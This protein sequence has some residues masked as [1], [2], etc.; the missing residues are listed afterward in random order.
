M[1]NPSAPPSPSLSGT[2]G[3]P[4]KLIVFEGVDGSGK[5]TQIRHLA[6]VL[7]RAGIPFCTTREPGGT[8]LGLHLRSILMDRE[9]P[10]C[11]EAELFLFLADRVQHARD[12]LRPALEAGQV[13][14]SDRLSDATMAYQGFGAGLPRD[15]LATLNRLALGAIV[16]DLTFLLD[17]PVS[18]I[19]GRIRA[20]A[21]GQTRFEVLGRDYF[22]R[23]RQGYLEMARVHSD[24]TVVLDATRPPDELKD[25]VTRA[26][27]GR[28]P[29]ECPL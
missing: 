4:G 26:L 3:R 19:E 16:P 23:V 11:T 18:E 12:L 9:V 24:R 27:S 15:L 13:V 21:D 22:E 6:G 29:E 8:P 14:L 28:F 2:P 20:R 5:S 17:L 10:L 1:K 7:E 25:A